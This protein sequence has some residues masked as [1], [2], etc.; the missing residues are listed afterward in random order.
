MN[1]SNAS[2]LA[3]VSLAIDFTQ[4]GI[5]ILVNVLL[6]PNAPVEIEVIP[7]GISNVP[8]NSPIGQ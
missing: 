4:L 6:P 2:Q 8:F 3:N 1:F 5:V 7:D